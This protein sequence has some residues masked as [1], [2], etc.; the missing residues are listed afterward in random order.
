[1]FEV[2]QSDPTLN[3]S[4]EWISRTIMFLRIFRKLYFS[5]SEAMNFGRVEIN[6]WFFRSTLSSSFLLE[7][8]SC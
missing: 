5:S 2:L 4:S 3:R 8:K 1:M 7:A 6:Y